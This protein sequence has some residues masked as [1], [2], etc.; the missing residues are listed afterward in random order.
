MR[1]NY[2]MRKIICMIDNYVSPEY[3]RTRTYHGCIYTSVAT[4]KVITD[5]N[6]DTY[7]QRDIEL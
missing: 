1:Y 3:V 5:D 7:M 6:V 2:D 4:D